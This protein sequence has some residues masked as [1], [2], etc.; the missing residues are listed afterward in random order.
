MRK[1]TFD[2][3]SIEITRRCNL[4]CQHCLRGDAQEVDI[5]LATIDALADQAAKVYGLSF[6]GGEPTLNVSA[7]EYTLEALRSRKV[8]LHSVEVGTNGVLLSRE[9]VEV[10]KGFS[11]YIAK[12]DNPGTAISVGIS[13]DHYHRGADPDAAF[14]FYRRELAGV[15]TVKLMRRGDVPV[16]VGRGR[17]LPEARPLPI[18]GS[19]PHQ[20][21]T[22]EKGK[23]CGCKERYLWPAS[24]AGEKIVCCRLSLSAHGDLTLCR[25][26]EGEYSAEDNHRNLVIC[27]LSPG[28][29]MG[30]RDIDRSIAEYN[31]RFPS[32]YEAEVQE[33]KIRT[34]EYM[35]YPRRA[36]DDIRWAYQIMQ[37]DPS[38]K[39]Q[40]L[41]QSP[42]LE[43][44]FEMFL[45]LLDIAE[46][47]PDEKLRELMER[48]G[49]LFN[50]WSGL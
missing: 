35:K 50:G 41:A 13:K 49:G 46:C 31:K 8:P 20:V 30:E 26:H 37:L 22:L 14:D 47:L 6:T 3:I 16:S 25:D 33:G 12:K 15:A 45:G 39:A 32:R 10:I 27:N 7:I 29:A 18:E 48:G 19:I 38:A 42:E 17:G 2:F 43:E 40:L 34:A 21:E 11:R 4:N 44:Q 5:D 24:Q 36:I 9:L 28:T 23:P 1:L